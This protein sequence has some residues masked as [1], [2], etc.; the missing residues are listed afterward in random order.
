MGV[1]N[2]LHP[3]YHCV[4]DEEKASQG[5]RLRSEQVRLGGME[6]MREARKC[7][8]L[9]LQ[10]LASLLIL[11][12]GILMSLLPPLPKNDWLARSGLVTFMMD[13]SLTRT[14]V[15]LKWSASEKSMHTCG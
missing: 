2:E 3:N 6:A 5:S 4:E 12:S 1:G 13:I 15:M 7:T 14:Y 11:T 10:S 8:R 9:L